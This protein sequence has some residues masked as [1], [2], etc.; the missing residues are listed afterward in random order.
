LVGLGRGTAYAVRVDEDG[1][2]WLE[3]YTVRLP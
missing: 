2:Q 3:R 1:L